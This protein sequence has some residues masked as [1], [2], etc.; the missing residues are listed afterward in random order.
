[1]FIKK[2]NSK[3]S[4]N[5]DVNI[6]KTF[7]NPFMIRNNSILS[8]N[9]N[10]DSSNSTD[11]KDLLNCHNNCEGNNKNDY[12]DNNSL[13]GN[14]KILNLKK[15]EVSESF[16]PTNF[17]DDLNKNKTTFY[18]E[19]EEDKCEEI[20]FDNIYR[21]Q[22]NKEHL[23][24]FEQ[25]NNQN[26]PLKKSI[27]TIFDKSNNKLRS[28]ENIILN[29]TE[30]FSNF[31]CY[32]NYNHYQNEIEFENSYDNIFNYSN[33]AYDITKCN[34]NEADIYINEKSI[35][36]NTENEF[37][38]FELIRKYSNNNNLDYN[39]RFEETNENLDNN[40]KENKDENN[41]TNQI[42][43]NILD[44][45]F[46]SSTIEPIQS[47][48]IDIG[49]E[50]NK[51]KNKNKDEIFTKKLQKLDKNNREINKS[52]NDENISVMNKKKLTFSKFKDDKRNSFV[53]NVLFYIKRDINCNNEVK[54][55]CKCKCKNS[56]CIKLYCECFNSSKYCFNCECPTCFNSKEYENIRSEAINKLLH[57]KKAGSIEDLIKTNQNIKEKGCKC[58][59]SSCLKNYCECFQIG[60]KCSDAC[61]C[62]GC[63]NGKNCNENHSDKI[64]NNDLVLQES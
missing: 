50:Y 38:N 6:S 57:K 12:F 35:K 45:L 31:D 19:Y 53:P 64:Q 54:E 16:L 17:F 4:K 21:N 61:M 27:D 18:Y 48:N 28:F 30:K 43:S 15:D 26:F 51:N 62:M 22:I 1:M 9:I 13:D 29:K 42:K 5:Y 60:N 10:S 59:N 52:S 23:Y 49:L 37:M 11:L 46:K 40:Y 44:S 24:S 56:H 32:K 3:S 36:E 7:S 25:T 63:K 58:K 20:K 47:T 41:E 14:N 2:E 8:E 34:S 33:N 55:K 39:Y